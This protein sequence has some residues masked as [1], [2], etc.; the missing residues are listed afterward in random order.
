MTNLPDWIQA[1]VAVGV[2]LL[3][4]AGFYFNSTNDIK[5]LQAQVVKME[6]KLEECSEE[7]EV[8]KTAMIKNK[9]ELKYLVDAQEEVRQSLKELSLEVREVHDAI[10]LLARTTSGSSEG[11][12]KK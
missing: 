9:H 3:A 12:G 5:M 1:T 11:D 7:V 10:L 8:L 2:I 4:I 6:E